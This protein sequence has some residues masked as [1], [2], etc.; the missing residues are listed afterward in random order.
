MPV[1]DEQLPVLLPD[2]VDY[3]GSGDNPLD[4]DEAFLHTTCPHVRRPGAGARPTRWT[5]SSTRR[6]TGCATCRRTRRTARSTG[7]WP[8]A[9]RPVDQYTG[10]AE[11]A[12]HAPAV[13]RFFTKALAD[14][15]LVHEREP[16][17]RLFNQGQILGADGERMSKSRGNVQD[18][19]E[20]VARYGADTVRLFLMFMGPWD[21]GGPWSPTGIDGVHRFLRR[22]WTVATRPARARARRS[23]AAAAARGRDR[24]DGRA[25]RSARPP[26][27]RCARSPRTTRSSTGTR[28]SPS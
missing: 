18:P 14:L 26:I 21:Q 16:F 9:G 22:V 8:S 1:P 24:G 25:T 7:A 13:R 11:H 3:Q 28:W 19:D 2:D 20:L 23:G 5:R 4:H 6:G 27:G 10:G 12:V 17:K 15:G